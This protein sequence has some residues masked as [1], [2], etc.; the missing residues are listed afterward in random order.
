M[1]GKTENKEETFAN[2]VHKHLGLLTPAQDVPLPVVISTIKELLMNSNENAA[3]TFIEKFAA[4]EV[5]RLLVPKKTLY[6]KVKYFLNLKG[7]DVKNSFNTAQEGPDENLTKEEKQERDRFIYTQIYF[8][9]IQ[10]EK[11]QEAGDLG[12]ELDIGVVSMKEFLVLLNKINNPLPEDKTIQTTLQ[13]TSAALMWIFKKTVVYP[14]EPILEI[15][16]PNCQTR[17]TIDK[18][19]VNCGVFV[20]HCNASEHSGSMMMTEK[21]RQVLIEEQITVVLAAG[22]TGEEARMA[23]EQ[24][25]PEEID[26]QQI[27][28]HL[29]TEE[30]RKLKEEKITLTEFRVCPS[31]SGFIIRRLEPTNL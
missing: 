6:E 21:I 1:N 15:I 5:L 28:N 8:S 13:N 30:K 10:G 24:Y 9:L 29:T 25:Y 14:Q 3:D 22:L 18:V 2:I 4:T 11:E 19:D 12:G 17:Y 27:P 23:A 7:D 31:N 16:C 20:C 26:N